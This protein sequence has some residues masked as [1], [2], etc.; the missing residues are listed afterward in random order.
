M[1]SAPSKSSFVLTQNMDQTC[2]YLH[3]ATLQRSIWLAI[4]E[5]MMKEHGIPFQTFPIAE[6]S[7]LKLERLAS[8]PCLFRWKLENGQRSKKMAPTSVKYLLTDLDQSEMDAYGFQFLSKTYMSAFFPGGR[9][10]A[11][12]R[13]AVTTKSRV[14]VNLIQLWDLGIMT[15]FTPSKAIA[16]YVLDTGDDWAPLHDRI[17]LA[18][19]FDGKEFWM[20][21]CR[22]HTG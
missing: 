12:H 15:H 21:V 7:R 13:T 4:V 11:T 17:R 5:R 10:L 14:H 3:N 8:S 9:F 1:V 2:R 22:R 19:S 20:V 6:F 16:S 18:P